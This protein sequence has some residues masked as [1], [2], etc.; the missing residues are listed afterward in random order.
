MAK[1]KM[2]M[3]AVKGVYSYSKNPMKPANKVAV[4]WG[5][6]KNP[7]AIKANKMLQKEHMGRESIRNMGI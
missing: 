5:P 1:G 2:S 6:G 3:S 7:D 4:S